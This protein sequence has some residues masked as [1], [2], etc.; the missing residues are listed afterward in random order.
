MKPHARLTTLVAALALSS[1]CSETIS[2]AVVDDSNV[3][4]N[5]ASN[6]ASN[7]V[8]KD[9]ITAPEDVTP[10]PDA[11]CPEG[12]TLCGGECADLGSST[13]HCGECNTRCPEGQVCAL[14]VCLVPCAV[15][16]TSC[17]G[18]C[19][20]LSTDT[21]NCGACGNG[22]A[23]GLGCVEGVCTLVCQ[24][25]RTNCGGRCVDT[26][27]SLEHCG[28]CEQRCAAG[29]RCVMGGCHGDPCGPDDTAEGRCDRD[30]IV[31]CV[32]GEIARETC[33]LG[34]TCRA[35]D[36]AA[37]A[38]LEPTGAKRVTGRITFQNRPATNRGV[39]ASRYDPVE[40]V[41]VALLDADERV[42]VQGLTDAD[43]AYSLP[44]DAA[45]GAMLR[46]RLGL[47]RTDSIYNF[48]VRDYAGA[49][50]S[51]TSAPFE[52]AATSTRD[53]AVTFEQ[54]SGALS[55]YVAARRA[56]EFLQRYITGRPAALYI[57][58]QR[59]RA[60]STSNSSYFS[61][62]S[63]TMFINGS[64][65]DPDEYDPPVVSH[66][67]GHYIQRWYSRSN[68]PGGPHDGSPADPK[69]AFG[70]GGASFLGSLITGSS[71]YIDAGVTRLRIAMDLQNIPLTRAYA[72]SASLSMDQVVSEWLVA[73]A[74]YA[75]FR[76]STD[77]TAQSQ[78]A[79]RVLTGYLRRTPTP[80]RGTDGVDLVDYLDG[81][82]CMN[83]GAD[84]ATI[85]SYLVTQRRFPYDF[86]FAEV[87][88]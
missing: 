50:F 76:T 9:A 82:L 12:N 84:R 29:T 85:M 34:R 72:A 67:F 49:T 21:N 1:A 40:G 13:S 16:Q 81:Y 75:M 42:V 48:V 79:M 24:S 15:G 83:D 68:N 70:E 17:E 60:T 87:C 18:E 61:G 54:N 20:S 8:A 37:P 14:G 58:W 53:M 5:D 28:G 38:C 25:G 88:R 71:Y 86:G 57:T 23:L 26:S 74:Q 64:A 46:V 2:P 47:A 45:D 51:F 33:V 69:L 80:D 52:A 7:G 65:A 3:A 36:G 56:F 63:S 59:G 27:T 6:D 55:I 30:T 44:Y 10:P 41:P 19:R 11:R 73:G 77:A 39:I 66:E 35:V 62:A 32:R 43:G 31:R 78:R 22:C 4:S